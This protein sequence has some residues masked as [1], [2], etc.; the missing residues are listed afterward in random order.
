MCASTPSGKPR[1][2]ARARGSTSPTAQSP[3]SASGTRGRR[4]DAVRRHNTQCIIHHRPWVEED[5]C[6]G[7]GAYVVANLLACISS[8]A[9]G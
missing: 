6:W 9:K 1:S 7:A 3:P 2:S 4:L 8:M 5:T